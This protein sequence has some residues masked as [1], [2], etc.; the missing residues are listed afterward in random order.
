MASGFGLDGGRDL[1]YI[2]SHWTVDWSTLSRSWSLFPLLARIQQVLCHCRPSSTMSWSTWRLPR[3]SPSHQGGRHHVI[4]AERERA[5]LL[6]WFDSLPVSLVSKP[7]SW[8]KLKRESTIS[9]SNKRTHWLQQ[10]QICQNWTLL[11]IK[12]QQRQSKF[13]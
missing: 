5:V 13:L 2:V 4:Q 1:L 7:R 8:S 10:S 6:T 11:M 9:R 12:S 3:V